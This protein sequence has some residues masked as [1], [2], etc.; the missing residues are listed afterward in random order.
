MTDW[1][2]TWGTEDIHG[3]FQV[4]PNCPITEP[5]SED[6]CVLPAEHVGK[7]SFQLV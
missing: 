5:I 4:L 3:E 6:A 7:H 1:W 2:A